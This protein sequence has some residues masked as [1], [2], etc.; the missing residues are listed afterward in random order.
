MQRVLHQTAR[1]RIAL[2]RILL[3]TEHG[4]WSFLIEPLIAGSVIAAS[5]AAPWIILM[6]VGGFFARQPLKV[7]SLLRTNPEAASRALQFASL[8]LAIAAVG[9]IGTVWNSGPQ[10]LFPLAV[11]APLA[12]QQFYADA[13]GRGRSLSAEL[14][15]ALAI[16]SSVAMM[17]SARGFLWPLAI[18][19]W[20]IFACRFVPSVL[21][22]RNR[23]ALEKGKP[24][25]RFWPTFAHFGALAVVGF[26]AFAGFASLLTVA[27]F[28]FLLARSILGLSQYRTRMK[29]MKIGIWEV[30]YGILTVVSVVVG[31]YVGI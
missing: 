4:A 13:T 5:F 23:L 11:A 21:Y 9:L 27:V 15:G 19:L 2:N 14:F 6:V 31:H 26:L 29:A 10:V 1:P 7:Y 25:D 16:S 20:V 17:A 30:A 22:V 12:L 28:V 3:P 18:S 8:F 24:Y